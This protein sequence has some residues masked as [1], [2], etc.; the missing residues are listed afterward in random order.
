L[1]GSGWVGAITCLHL[2]GVGFGAGYSP[3][4]GVDPGTGRGG[5]GRTEEGRPTAATERPEAMWSRRNG[6]REWVRAG[7]WATR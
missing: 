4:A 2:G 5:G 1:N 6:D 3:L 7:I